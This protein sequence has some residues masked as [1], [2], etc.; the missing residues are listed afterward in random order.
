[1]HN[2]TL[3]M[4]TFNLCSI[5]FLALQLWHVIHTWNVSTFSK[6]RPYFQ[7]WL[8]VLESLLL[9]ASWSTKTCNILVK[10]ND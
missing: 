9:S 5:L 7:S 4:L 2:F 8:L 10:S 1:M 3:N 6:T